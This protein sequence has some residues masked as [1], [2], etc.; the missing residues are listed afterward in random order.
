MDKN[1]PGANNIII[2]GLKETGSQTSNNN[3]NNNNNRIQSI[4]HFFWHIHYRTNS[5]S[6]TN[7]SQSR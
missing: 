4:Y 5:F 1:T 2:L 3:N 7:I 6:Y